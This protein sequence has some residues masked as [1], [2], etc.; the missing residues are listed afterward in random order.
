MLCSNT[1]LKF[2]SY[3]IAVLGKTVKI[4]PVMFMNVVIGKRKYMFREYVA[5]FLITLG[6]VTFFIGKMLNYKSFQL[7]SKAVVT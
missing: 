5:V 7:R 3:P 4:I 6:I 1:A 2:V